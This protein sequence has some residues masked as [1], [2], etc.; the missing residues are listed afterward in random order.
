MKDKKTEIYVI[1]HNT[2]DIVNIKE[3][4]IYK[5]L[6]VGCNGQDNLGYLSDDTGDNI[7]YKNNSFCE[8]TGL[9]WMWKNSDA[10]IIG[11]THYR[12][13]FVKKKYGK[14][15]DKNDLNRIF[16]DYDIILPKKHVPLGENLYKDYAYA[17]NAKDLDL[18][19]E[20]IKDIHPE[21]LESFDDMMKT[22]TIYCFNM[23]IAPKEIITPYC[24]WIF[25]ILF[26][27]EKRIDLTGYNNYQQ[28]V[29]GFL[30]ERLFK[31]WLNKQNLKIKEC[32]VKLIGVH[33]NIEQ[34]IYRKKIF[35]FLFRNVYLKYF[36]KEENK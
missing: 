10:D 25:S 16:K 21:Y 6:F 12:R 33:L 32:N 1:S 3:D 36:Y 31:V 15:L 13:Y 26:E 20:I 18:C 24:E 29:Y 35:I 28:R 9:Y 8:L 4:K 34:W 5:P 14:R 7:S 27:L 11:L 22:D 17:H 30:S 2:K 23:F 19:R